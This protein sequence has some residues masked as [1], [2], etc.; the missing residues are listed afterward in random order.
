MKRV[1]WLVVRYPSGRLF[2]P[3]SEKLVRFLDD[4]DV[5]NITPILTFP[6]RGGRELV[7]PPVEGEGTRFHSP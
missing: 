5:L 1:G 3:L 4:F 6:R 2:Q 7:S